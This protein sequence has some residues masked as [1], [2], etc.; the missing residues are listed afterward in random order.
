MNKAI[1]IVPEEIDE[2]LKAWDKSDGI[3]IDDMYKANELMEIC[4]KYGKKYSEGV[5]R[6]IIAQAALFRVSFV[7]GQR[8]E[9]KKRA[10]K[11]NLRLK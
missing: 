10:D 8:Y 11:S 9:R 1:K 2:L 7:L 5:Y 6:E 3:S 4:T